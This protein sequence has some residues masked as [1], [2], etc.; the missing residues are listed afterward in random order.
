MPVPEHAAHRPQHRNFPSAVQEFLSRVTASG[1]KAKEEP[2]RQ[3]HGRRNSGRLEFPKSATPGR[4][5]C[6]ERQPKSQLHLKNSAPL[7]ST[8]VSAMQACNAHLGSRCSKARLLLRRLRK[9]F[10]GRCR[11]ILKGLNIGSFEIIC[12]INWVNKRSGIIIWVTE[13]AAV[14]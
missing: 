7:L 12:V 13:G 2:I 1:P 3:S 4:S 14:P 11:E 6:G 8:N 9:S 10:A 5:P